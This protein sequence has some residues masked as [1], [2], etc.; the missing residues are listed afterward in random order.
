TYAPEIQKRGFRTDL[1]IAANPLQEH[2]T[3]PL[4]PAVLVLSGAVGLVLLIACVNLANLLLARAGSRR[5]E[6][7]VRLALGSNRGRIVRQMLTE[8]LMLA[9]PGGLAGIAIAWL[10]VELLDRWKPAILVRYP[11]IAMEWPV[12][13][14]TLGLTLATSLLFGIAPALAA[15]GTHI[16]ET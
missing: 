16:Q 5:R 11:A 10:G 8:S 1:V 7:A 14:F 2:L 12:L 6:I 9:I 13:A 4:R 15:A 3:G